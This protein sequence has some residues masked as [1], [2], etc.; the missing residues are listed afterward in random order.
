LFSLKKSRLRGDLITLHNSVKGGGGEV[1]IS[2]FSH[3]AVT[4]QEGMA[5]REGSGW[6]LGN[7]SSQKEQ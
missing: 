1:G 4:G 3:I 6:R 7:I 5:S 2:L